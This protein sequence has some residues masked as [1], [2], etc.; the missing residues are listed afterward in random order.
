MACITP[1]CP[2]A[3]ASRIAVS[4]EEQATFADQPA[5]HKCRATSTWPNSAATDNGD[6]TCGPA[7]GDAHKSSTTLICPQHAATH[8][9]DAS[10]LL[11]PMLKGSNSSTTTGS[12]RHA[13]WQSKDT[14]PAPLVKYPH[15]RLRASP[16]RERRPASASRRARN[17]APKARAVPHR[18]RALARAPS[19]LALA[20][21]RVPDVA[22]ERWRRKASRSARSRACPSR[23]KRMTERASASSASN[24]ATRRS[25]RDN[26]WRSWASTATIGVARVRLALEPQRR[27][28]PGSYTATSRATAPMCGRA[29]HGPARDASGRTSCAPDRPWGRRSPG[30]WGQRSRPWDRPINPWGRWGRRNRAWAGASCRVGVWGRRSRRGLGPGA[31][32]PPPSFPRVG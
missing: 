28:T 29:C 14:L 7:A 11:A 6:L 2:P 12:P 19:A 20:S 16:S 31:L 15:A 23:S 17:M 1:M 22:A 5:A 24:C 10:P 8:R 27:R 30:Q 18:P 3:A 4:P 26:A 25:K 9:G 21:L 32:L 13:A